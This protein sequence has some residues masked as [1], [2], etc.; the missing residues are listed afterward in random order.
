MLKN[1]IKIAM[2]GIIASC[3][4]LPLLSIQPKTIVVPAGGDL[5]AAINA[6]VYGDTI[7]VEKGGAFGPLL[8]TQSGI[9]I[10]TSGTLPAAGSRP[11]STL[12]NQFPKVVA[13]TSAPAL[14]FAA[15]VH[16]VKL[17]GLIITN[18]GGN[19]FTDELILIG[20]R[21]S[22]GSI[23]QANKPHNI[24]FDQCWVREATNDTTTPDAATTTA[25][26]GFDVSAPFVSITNSR[27]RGFRAYKGLGA[28]SGA[29]ASNAILL[30][31]ATNFTVTNSDL[32][33]WFVPVFA[34]AIADSPNKAT[35]S[36][37]SFNP[38]T[39]VGSATFSNVQNLTTGEIVAFK[40]SGGHT[41][42]TN[43]AHPNE[44]VVFQVGKVTAIAGN[45]VTY[46]GWGT[47]D[48]DLKGGNPLTQ[49]PDSPGLAQ[50]KGFTNQNIT[51][52]RNII[53]TPF[54]ASEKIWITSGGSPTTQ[55]RATQSNT[56]N[57]PKSAIELKS[58]SNCLIDGNTQDGWYTSFVLMT[59]RNQGNTLTSG[60]APW[61]G[62]FDI[63]ITNNFVRRMQNWDRIYSLSLGGPQLEDNEYSNVRSGPVLI[64]NNLFAGGMDA[65]LSSM[66]AA[67]NVTYVH[68]TY[69]GSTATGGSMIVAQG[70][71]SAN[72]TFQN[73]I[74]SNNQYGMNC[75]IAGGCTWPGKIQSNNVIS[76]NRTPDTKIGDG[77][78]RY[79]GDFVVAS[80]S[81][82]GWTDPTN[83]N[84][85]L[86]PSSPFKGKASDGKDPGVDMDQLLAALGGILPSPTP[87]P[88]VQPSPTPTV[89]PTPG[90]TPPDS[91]RVTVDVNGVVVRSQPL[92][93]S[94]GIGTQ[95][96]G[97]AGTLQT[98]CVPDTASGKTFCFVAFD[99][100][101]N[102]SGLGVSGWLTQEHLVFLNPQPSPT[103]S[104][105]PSPSPTPI[106]TGTFKFLCTFDKSSATLVCVPVP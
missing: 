21:S 31:G 10:T 80:Q 104:P 53:S 65:A 2:F 75:Q 98:P 85:R 47:F 51:I 89:T 101:T 102:G 39:N 13:N 3:A 93:S 82:V 96:A 90:P 17:S 95:N 49:A 88:T 6:S 74:L 97:S 8:V 37:V 87:T 57:A 58:C 11:D 62:D 56:G 91:N 41:P 1:H 54:N 106:P 29:E 4:V 19:V 60:G 14:E 28:T 73:N 15:D 61:A 67:D 77:P 69:P 76:D 105:S 68:N 78:L 81:A 64:A 86:L 59:P 18:V 35:L 103:P 83:G 32:E 24:S 92:S 16:D 84:Y 5:Q 33:S 45:V 94:P 7:V 66:G 50:W 72:F 9:T 40:V 23:P 22:G 36:T 48:G 71:Q 55:P 99:N 30:A 52:Q 12:E 26:R 79:P 34:S 46:Q 25:D 100:Q 20:S 27:I 43:N 70:A 44:S 38:T 63:R 42:Q